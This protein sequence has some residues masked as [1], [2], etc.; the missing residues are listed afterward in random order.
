M[1]ATFDKVKFGKFLTDN[2]SPAPFGVGYCARYVRHALSAAGVSPATW[3]ESAKDWGPSLVSVGFKEHA[4]N[5]YLAVGGLFNACSIEPFVPAL[6]D[7]V[8]TQGTSRS[9]DGHM[10]GYNGTAWVS[11]FVQRELWPG[12]SYRKE[13]PAYVVYRWAF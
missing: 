3:L 6:G 9:A 8:V 10:A 13:K 4:K 11:D 7:V 12:P 5:G 2:V 1:A